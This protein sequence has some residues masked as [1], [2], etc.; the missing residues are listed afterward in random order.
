MTDSRG[1]LNYRCTAGIQTLS[2]S[3]S[4]A[5]FS[6]NNLVC[7]C[8]CGRVGHDM[9][10]LAGEKEQPH[11]ANVAVNHIMF[12]NARIIKKKISSSKLNNNKNN[13]V[14]LDCGPYFQ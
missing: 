8:V 9:L 3:P 4:L 1:G 6:A 13:K 2:Y 11:T 10:T 12:L 7:V 14:V 5:A